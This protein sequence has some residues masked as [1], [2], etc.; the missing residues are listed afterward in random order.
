MDASSFQIGSLLDKIAVGN[1][2]SDKTSQI[3]AYRKKYSDKEK[4]ELGIIFVNLE[5]LYP[6]A[7]TARPV[8]RLLPYDDDG[9][10]KG[11]PVIEAEDFGNDMKIFGKNVNTYGFGFQS[12]KI[13]NGGGGC[14]PKFYDRI[15]ACYLP[16]S[17]EN[18]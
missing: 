1:G 12:C 3:L 2:L 8:C 15:L 6:C 7:K 5:K 16:K 9:F 4:S 18:S 11:K 17:C 14:L 10:V 13:L